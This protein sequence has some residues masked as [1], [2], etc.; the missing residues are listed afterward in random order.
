MMIRTFPSGIL[1]EKPTTGPCARLL[2][3]GSSTRVRPADGAVKRVGSPPFTPD[4]ACLAMASDFRDGGDLI[5]A[6]TSFPRMP[7]E[8][9]FINQQLCAWRR[10]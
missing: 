4:A 3:M 8:L 1:V 7:D 5:L 9:F 6:G 10:T 2:E